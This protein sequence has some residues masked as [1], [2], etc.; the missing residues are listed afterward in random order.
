MS[1]ARCQMEIDSAEFSEWQ[2]FFQLSP[3]NHLRNDYNSA[4]ICHTLVEINRSKN[5]KRTQLGDFVLNFD[6][7]PKVAK[8]PEQLLKEM[9]ASMKG[10]LKEA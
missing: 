7:K 1:V 2:A 8:T 6:S 5:S 9:T 3:P 4:N 10:R